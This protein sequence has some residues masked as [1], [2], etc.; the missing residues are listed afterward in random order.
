MRK[1]VLRRSRVQPSRI[2]GLGKARLS[3]ICL[4]AELGLPV[5]MLEGLHG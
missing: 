3:V 1:A 4:Y 2:G 5:Q